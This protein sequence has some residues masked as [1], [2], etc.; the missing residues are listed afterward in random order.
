MN[1]VRIRLAAGL[2]ST[3]ILLAACGGSGD[4]SAP[5]SDPPPP[6]TS[7]SST[8]MFVTS[9]PNTGFMNQLNTFANH[10]TGREDQ[11]A[12]GDLWLRYAD[13]SLRNLTQEAGW[14]VASG[15]IQGGEL[16]ISVRQPTIH[17]DGHK[18]IF[19]M[20]T[21]GA[22]AR[23]QVVNRT[24]QLYEVSGLGKNETAVISKVP[25]QPAY[26]NM[27]PVYASDDQILFT[28]DAPLYGMA[29]TWPQ[30]DEYESTPTVT[31]IWRLNPATGAVQMI[32]HAPSGAFDLLVD[33][34]GRVLFTKW[35]H[36]KRDQQADLDR[37]GAGT[38]KTFDVADESVTAARTVF[39]ALDG[40]GRLQADAKGVLYDV[41]PEARNANDPTRDPNEELHDF[42]QFFIWQVN[43]DGS[44]EETLNHVGRNEVGGTY[45]DGVF[46]DDP[47][48]NDSLGSFT[49]NLAM[50]A[51]VRSDSGIFQLK[52]DPA[53]AGRYY[54]TYAQEFSRQASG[55]I[56]SFKLAPGD[57]PEDMVMS[58]L[59]NATL[60]SD[61]DG[62]NPPLATMTGHYRNALKL[63]NGS[64]VVAHTPEYRV[65][66]NTSSDPLL[67]APR[68]VFQL[69]TF[70]ALGAG[71]ERIA[72]AALTGGLV[73]DIRYWTDEAAPI[74]YVGPL[75]EHDVVE[76]RPRPRPA[77]TAMSIDPLEKAVLNEEGVDESILRSW[78]I[79]RNLALIV[80]RNTTIRDRA[81]TSQPFNLRVPG[82]VS[83]QP[84]AGKLY[85]VRD[86][87][88]LQGDLTRSY[89]DGAGR[90]RRVYARPM[91]PSQHHPA[92]DSH[93]PDNAAGSP[94]SVRIAADGSLAAFV[95]AGR[96]LTWQLTSPAGK[97]VVRERNWVTFAPGEIRTCASCHGVNRKAAGNVDEPV[98]KPQAL[99]DLLSHWKT[100]NGFSLQRAGP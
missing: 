61:P 15:A 26:N 83:S 7:S 44:G 4:S 32:E 98:N 84:A 41:F 88:I 1:V 89:G 66:R 5:P 34:F 53:V 16:A 21:G 6:D 79:E 43:Q 19:A 91:H 8:L 35:D 99:R 57:N 97:A 86:L 20:L 46:M 65:N 92:M 95:P 85:D 59:T 96:A 90:G 56:V 36:L 55:R 28:S 76:V 50:R 25:H 52:E 69:R 30:L 81:D 93:N 11:I 70:V 100:S 13:G 2:A 94:G 22:T 47:N 14:G 64:W 39:P 78:L 67:R 54:G 68:Y 87:Q 10:G 23:Y 72:G 58:D 73:K 49:A 45:M 48:L 37:Y 9:V 80:T 17:W 71:S 75:N 60:D 18:A 77:V 82:G 40:N 63:A 62:I 31:G 27:S 38:Y 33:S 12:G 29:H 24:W 74:R 3:L 42:N 51:T